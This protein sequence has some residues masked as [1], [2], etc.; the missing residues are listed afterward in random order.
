MTD[1]EYLQ[2]PLLEGLKFEITEDSI[3]I[4]TPCTSFFNNSRPQKFIQEDIL[5]VYKNVLRLSKELNVKISYKNSYKKN[6]IALWPMY[7]EELKEYDVIFKELVEKVKV[8]EQRGIHSGC[9]D[10][11]YLNECHKAGHKLNPYFYR[12]ST[13][14][15]VREIYSDLLKL[16]EGLKRQK[17]DVNGMF[18]R[19]T[20]IIL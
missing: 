20:K 19:Y 2:R 6:L 3:R 12:T 4:Q 15:K 17:K 10:D 7:L 13:I 14:S 16:E 8:L 11:A 1:K 9:S 18:G 5:E